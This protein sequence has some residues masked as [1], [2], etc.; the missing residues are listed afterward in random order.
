M[1]RN[2]GLD[3]SHLLQRIAERVPAHLRAHV[4]VIGSI[5]TAWA[6]RDVSGTHAVA[7]KD[8]DVLLRP[9]IDAVATAQALGQELLDEGWQPRYPNGVQPGTRQ[10]P[11]DQLPALRLSPPGEDDSWYVELLAE[12]TASQA[13]RKH[14]QRFRTR[15][16][17]FGLPSFRYLRVAAHDADDTGFGLRV[18]R[19][20]SMA[21]AHLLEHADPIT[22]GRRF[23]AYRLCQGLL[24]SRRRQV[25]LFDE[26][27]DVFG[28]DDLMVGLLFGLSSHRSPEA[29]RKSWINQTLE[30]NPIPT[31]WVCNS[32]GALDEAYLRRFDLVL[33]FTAP[34]TSAR[35]RIVQRYFKAGEI[36]PACEARLASF[37]E[38]V[39]AFV[40]KAARVVKSLRFKDMASRDFEV[41]RLVTS[42]LKATGHRAS[43]SVLALPEHYDAAFL[44]TDID[45]AMLAE[46]LR[47]GKVGARLCLYGAPGT[48][49]TA[50]AH[51]LGKMLDRS[52]LVKRGSD[53]ISKW[54]GETEQNIAEAFRSAA[55]DNAILVIDEADG[56]LRDRAGA[57]RQWEVTQVNELLTQMEAFDG[58]FVASTNLVDTLDAASLRRFD[59]KVK[60]DWLTRDQ[61]RAMLAKVCG[62]DGDRDAVFPILDR[63]DQLAPGDFANVLRQLRVT[64][65]EATPERV[66]QRLAQEVAMKPGARSRGVGFTAA[67]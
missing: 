14:W 50:F 23:G 48:G 10:T 36:S 59:F 20:A 67:R 62:G 2:Q 13:T 56:F 27:E 60:F 63:L 66:V 31:F 12:P 11:A 6:F 65:E 55:N 42:M 43:T 47:H 51:H 17:D 57:D 54:V 44:N 53:L 9:A 45:L 34:P 38:L 18:A 46:G 22:G 61:R 41:E 49:K 7:T 37:D 16:G 33:E 4:V 58:I 35:R 25:L 3:A 29:L 28:T 26:V 32:I 52:V 5:A 39:P 8:I 19:P 64:G 21:L 1:N 40:Q 15:L 24:A 30:E